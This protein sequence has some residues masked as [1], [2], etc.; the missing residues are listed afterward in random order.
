MSRKYK[1][2]DQQQAYFVSFA[3]VNWID[4][5]TRKI[6]NDILV[7]SL[8]YCQKRKSVDSLCLVYNAKSC[9]FNHWH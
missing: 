7:E 4:I 3:V 9:S 1:F 6:Y 8:S 2:L 5:F